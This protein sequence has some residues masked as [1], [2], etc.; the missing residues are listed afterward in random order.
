MGNKKAP[1]LYLFFTGRRLWL[2]GGKVPESYPAYSGKMGEY[3]PIPSGTYWI[4]H[5]EVHKLEVD[6]DLSHKVA[7]AI[8]HGSIE[9]AFLA[10]QTGWGFYRIPIHQNGSQAARN[11]RDNFFIHGGGIPGSAGCIDLVEQ[12]DVFVGCLKQEVK[13]AGIDRIPLYVD[14]K[15]EGKGI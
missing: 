14:N 4:N 3:E 12:M 13:W 1:G 6:D 8:L 15:Y 10:H 7:A 5:S 9:K 2:A 11:G